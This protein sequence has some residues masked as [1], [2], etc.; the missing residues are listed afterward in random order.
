MKISNC[1]LW[2]LCTKREIPSL[3]LSQFVPEVVYQSKIYLPKELD[4]L[5]I[6]HEILVSPIKLWRFLR[7]EY[8]SHRLHMKRLHHNRGNRDVIVSALRQKIKWL[9]SD[10]N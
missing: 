10:L 8:T 9:N 7:T 6:R 3:D 2:S 4:P 1:V 5:C